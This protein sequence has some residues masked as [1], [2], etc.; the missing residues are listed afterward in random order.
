[1]Q[2]KKGKWSEWISNEWNTDNSRPLGY[3]GSL[4]VECEV[5]FNIDPFSS[6]VAEL[7]WWRWQNEGNT[8]FSPF[9]GK[10]FISE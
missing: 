2:E 9:S 10:R 3:T 8:T 5:V 4:D 1:M 7:K 6:F